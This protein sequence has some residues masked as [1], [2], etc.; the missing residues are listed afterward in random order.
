MVHEAIAEF[1]IGRSQCAFE[2]V[3][4]RVCICYQPIPNFTRVLLRQGSQHFNR[5]TFVSSYGSTHAHIALL[6]Q[7]CQQC[8]RNLW[9][10]C[11][12]LPDLAISHV[13]E[14]FEQARRSAWIGR[15]IF[16]N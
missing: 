16:A 8:W 7:L 9:M 1:A 5:C 6:R 11:D 12:S 15:E 3:E 14:R 2:D 4:W 10:A 13:P